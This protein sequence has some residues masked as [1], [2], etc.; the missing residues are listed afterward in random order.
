[1]TTKQNTLTTPCNSATRPSNIER[2]A[3]WREIAERTGNAKL[4]NT[5]DIL[6]I[7]YANEVTLAHYNGRPINLYVD[8]LEIRHANEAT[9]PP[10]PPAKGG[11][12]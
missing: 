7:R 11:D 5:V 8:I 12:A 4:I 3:Q 10:V 2:I 6:E 1:M 9:R